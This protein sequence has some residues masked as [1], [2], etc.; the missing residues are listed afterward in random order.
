MVQVRTASRRNAMMSQL[1]VSITATV[2]ATLIVAAVQKWGVFGWPVSTGPETASGGKFTARV[3]ALRDAADQT[4]AAIPRPRIPLLVAD[5]SL[6]TVPLTLLVDSPLD[7]PPSK[8]LE[9][10]RASR[11]LGRVEGRRPAPA[12]IEVVP[13]RRSDSVTDETS[14]PLAT[15]AESGPSALWTATKGLYRQAKWVGGQALDHVNPMNLL[16]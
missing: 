12:T 15:V 5:A 9:P 8:S 11:H 3:L 2:A 13:P 16:P 7:T 10:A 14:T 6:S 4:A 1:A